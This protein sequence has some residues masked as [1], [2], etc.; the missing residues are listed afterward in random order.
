MAFEQ[1]TIK[2]ASEREFGELRCAIEQVLSPDLV[3]K[4]L[5]ALSSRGIRVRDLDAILAAK[6][7]DQVVGNKS[8]A[9]ALYESLPVSD[10]AQLREFYLSKIE[11]VD[12]ALRA[13]FHKLYQYS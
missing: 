3:V 13:K 8:G 11:E 5:K 9:A 7:I 1:A 12:S 10:Q 6:V 2:V 4:F